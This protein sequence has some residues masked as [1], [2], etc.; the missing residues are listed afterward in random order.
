MRSNADPLGERTD[1]EVAAALAPL[2]A[3]APGAAVD[4][5]GQNL[6]AGDRVAKRRRARSA[7]LR[8]ISSQSPRIERGPL[9]SLFQDLEK[10]LGPTFFFL[11]FVPLLVTTLNVS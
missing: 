2:T 4:D 3:L 1:A 10:R 6:S 8:Y 5:A 11:R 7:V 9:A